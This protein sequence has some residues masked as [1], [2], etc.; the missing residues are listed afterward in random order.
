MKPIKSKPTPDQI[1]V[2]EKLMEQLPNFQPLSRDNKVIRS[3]LVEVAEKIH[4]RYRKL[5]RSS[6]LFTSDKTIG[7]EL[8]YHEASA[9]LLFIQIM[10]P[11]LPA[12]GK[13]RNDLFQFSNFLDKKLT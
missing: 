12:Q 4:T 8:K 1:I 13:E 2:L 9:I 6:D 7:L 11:N 5:V 10:L 3:I